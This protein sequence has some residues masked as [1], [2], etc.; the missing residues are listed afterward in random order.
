MSFSLFANWIEQTGHNHCSKLDQKNKQRK[1]Q[2]YLPACRIE[3][4]A[5][6]SSAARPA[7][8]ASRESTRRRVS[9]AQ[10]QAAHR[11]RTRCRRPSRRRLD[12]NRATDAQCRRFELVTHALPFSI[13]NIPRKRNEQTN[14]HQPTIHPTTTHRCA[15]GRADRRRRRLVNA[16]PRRADDPTPCRCEK[17]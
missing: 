16:S 17:R 5:Q 1:S 15:T 4:A 3:L 12:A 7:R 10:S 6:R 14:Q 9:C 13:R 2:R 8:S 11:A